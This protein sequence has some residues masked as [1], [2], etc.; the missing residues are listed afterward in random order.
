MKRT[1]Q[2][3]PGNQ[4]FT[5][6]ELMVVV[7]IIGILAAVALP[8][9]K[10]YQ[11]KSKTSEAKLILASTFMAETGAY[12]DY[13]SYVTCLDAVGFSV[14]PDTSRYYAVGFAP[15]LVAAAIAGNS[16]WGNTFVNTNYN[17]TCSTA[18]APVVNKHYFLG[19]KPVPGATRQSLAT[20]LNTLS[21]AA[22]GSFTIAAAGI[23]QNDD[24]KVDKWTIDNLKS[25]K[26]TT[27]GY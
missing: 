20:E 6:V 5:L 7:A 2:C 3:L 16:T 21:V 27:V 12:A 9:F 17:N 24:T 23:I 22:Q 14:E 26:Q 1:N 18:A 8:N 19:S 25:I 13:T 11:A 10:K 15:D 4:G